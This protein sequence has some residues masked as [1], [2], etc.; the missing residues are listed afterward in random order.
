[1]P[2]NI[3]QIF[4]LKYAFIPQKRNLYSIKICE[5][6]ITILNI[7]L[8]VCTYSQRYRDLNIKSDAIEMVCT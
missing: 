8:L 3:C 5:I 7:I 4:S 2:F 6:F 1:M